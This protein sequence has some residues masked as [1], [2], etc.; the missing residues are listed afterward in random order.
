[1]KTHTLEQ[2]LENLIKN[3][4]TTFIASL[5]AEGFPALKAM[6]APR[7]REGLRTFWFS[8]NTSSERVAHYQANPKAAIYFCDRL[9]FR[10]V[11]L[12]GYMEVLED[13]ETKQMIWKRN[14]TQYYKKGV[15]DPDY[16]VLKF[17]ATKGRYY[18]HFHAQTFSIDLNSVRE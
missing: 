13:A 1:M 4:K 15:S 12:H 7:K 10:A 8:T 11:M 17:T 16:C 2:K 9:F 5:D 3:R 14:D 18:E 6:L